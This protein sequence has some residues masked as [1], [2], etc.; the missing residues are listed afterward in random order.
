MDKVISV[1]LGST[2]RDFI[3]DLELLGRTITLQRRGVSGGF[4]EDYLGVLRE[5]GMDPEVRAIGLAGINRYLFTPKGRCEFRTARKIAAAA[6]RKPVVDGCGLKS[7]LEPAIIHQLQQEGTVDFANSRVL[8]V[9]AV[10]RWPMAEALTQYAGEIRYGDLMFAGDLP[11]AISSWEK[12]GKVANL[13]VPLVALLVPFEWV[14]PGADSQVEQKLGEQY[15]W[16]DVIAGEW[17]FIRHYLP[18]SRAALAGKVIITNMVTAAEANELQSRGVKLLITTT[19]AVEGRAYTTD[20][21]EA[22]LVA[23]AGKPPERMTPDEY[24]DLLRRLGWDR[25]GVLQFSL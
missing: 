13:L 9:C 20:V 8:M 14:Y 10:D 23:L 5:V 19:P 12:L 22:L 6:M 25:P 4:T 21:V 1:A 3:Q 18:T 7:S 24:L 2:Q 17:R 15:A 16:A 11:F